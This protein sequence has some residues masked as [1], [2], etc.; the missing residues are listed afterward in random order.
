MNEKIRKGKLKSS[1]I[2][3]VLLEQGNR[4]ADNNLAAMLDMPLLQQQVA[5]IDIHA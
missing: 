5:H 1:H 3:P 2:L 4:D